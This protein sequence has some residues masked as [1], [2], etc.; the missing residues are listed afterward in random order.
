MNG[1]RPFRWVIV[2]L[3][4]LGTVINY[5]DRQTLST[6]APVI[7]KDLHLTNTAYGRIGFWFLIV[8]AVS[9]SLWG[10]V[11]DRVG[12]RRGYAAAIGWWSIAEIAHAFARG[13]FSLCWLRGALGAGESG[14]WPGATR[15]VAA[16]FAEQQRALAMGIVNAGA[17][18]G[19]A[20]ATPLIVMLQ[21]AFGWKTVFISTGLLGLVWV[22]AWVAVYPR[23]GAERDADGETL[24]SVPRPD[25]TRRRVPLPSVSPHQ[26]PRTGLLRQRVVWGIILAR[27]FGDPIWWLF[28]NWL[29]K[30]L[31]DV[32]G[33]S[34][35]RVGYLGWLPFMAAVAGGVLGGAVSGALIRRGWTVN[36]TRKSVIG[37]ATVLMLAGAAT[38]LLA[39]AAMALTAMAI[40]CFGFQMWVGSVQTL[41]SDY[42]PVSAVGR[43]AGYSGTAAGLGAALFTLSIG[44]IVDAVSYTPVFFIAGGLAVLATASLFLL[45]G[46]VR[47]LEPDPSV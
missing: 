9:M 24:G 39:S 46:R 42:Y 26:A 15:T 14:N 6:L 34:L 1:V 30:Y 12:N 17:G 28:L 8:Y 33:F 2:G 23:R 21:L 47:R 27:W 11:F 10:F 44:K 41:P 32:R 38:P 16:W 22:V 36:A 20:I 19:S 35:Q 29:P 7:S 45:A 25:E 43:I 13:F 3:L 40:T 31:Y 5:I 18:L 37:T 4:F